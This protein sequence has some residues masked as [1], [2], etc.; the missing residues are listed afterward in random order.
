[1]EHDHHH[2]GA[3]GKIA[4]EGDETQKKFQGGGRAG[5]NTAEEPGKYN[6]S[7]SLN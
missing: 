1:M 7:S 2:V 6:K 5:K 3:G 4:Q